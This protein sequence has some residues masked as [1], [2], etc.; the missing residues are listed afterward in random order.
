VT[1]VLASAGYPASPRTGEEI[2]G[3]GDL[4]AGVEVTHAG[5]V[6][7]DGRVLT[8]GGRVLN[9]TALGRDPESARAAAY[10]AAQM[11]SFQGMQL[12][13]DIAADAL[14]RTP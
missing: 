1:L 6:L 10:A 4:P 7:E 13:G 14:R 3:L 2:H 11:V 12:R 8:A 9:L 5:S